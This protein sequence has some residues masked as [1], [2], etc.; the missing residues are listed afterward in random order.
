MTPMTS[1][2]REGL[3]ILA[4]G[5]ALGVAAD[6]LVHTVP[7]RLNLAL[8]MGALALVFLALAQRE[9]I[10]LPHRLAPIG[11]LLGLLCVALVWRDS[12]TLFALNLLAMA[13]L[14][15]LASPRV[16]AVCHARAGLADYIC[17]ADQIVAGLAFGGAPLLLSD[18]E[19]R[20]L[21]REGRAR[22]IG[23]AA[24][25]LAAA[26]PVITV[27]GGLLMDSDPVFYRLMSDAFRLKIDFLVEHG[28]AICVWSWTAA[29]LLRVFTKTEL[30]PP[31]LPVGWWAGRLR[32]G[33][34]GTVVAL[35]DLLFL[36]FVAVQFRYLFGGADL[37]RQVTGLSYAEYARSGF[38][39]LVAV[40]ALSL[41]LLLFADWTLDGQDRQAVRV[42]RRLACLMLVLL[43]VILASALFR[44]RLYTL[45]YGLTELRFYTSAF[46]GWLVLV[47]GW[48][49]A[50]V[51]RGRRPRFAS[52]AV[53]AALLVLLSLNLLN[54]DG[55]IVATNLSRAAVGRPLDPAYTAALS[56]DALPILRRELHTL[57]RGQACVLATLLKD[58]WDAEFAHASRWDM[59]YVR[60]SRARWPDGALRC[61]PWN[62]TQ[63]GGVSRRTGVAEQGTRPQL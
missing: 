7:E 53:T 24:V 29:G 28:L 17:G 26:V 57:P 43:N 33:Q 63:S 8:G 25:G 3:A 55:M 13:G 41:P 32:L 50:T 15:T 61:P 62:Q 1:R 56:A 45:E 11:V 39:E 48:F 20:S 37:V 6:V 23:D 49:A 35:V 21:S 16:V 2:T 40:V 34:V 22:V 47:F 5:I 27:F 51:L 42:F 9:L 46:M 30:R 60:A 36:A 4:A 10:Y 52:G 54:P 58:R 12:P 14:L 19:W 44:M 31:G 38:F 18:I 59:S